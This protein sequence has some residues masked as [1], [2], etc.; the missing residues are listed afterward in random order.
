MQSPSLNA[1]AGLRDENLADVAVVVADAV[2]DVAD[3]KRAITRN[4]LIV[5]TTSIFDSALEPERSKRYRFSQICA[6]NT[7]CF[8]N[9]Q[10]IR[11]NGCD[12]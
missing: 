12:S 7:E 5:I 1:C 4:F 8:R 6:R 10:G 9:E 3:N 11:L 2:A